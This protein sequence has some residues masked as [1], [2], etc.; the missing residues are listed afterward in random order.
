M[1]VKWFAVDEALS[2]RALA[3][4][5]LHLDKTIRIE[6]PALLVYE[7]GNATLSVGGPEL[8]AAA[9]EALDGFDLSV[10]PPSPDVDLD[11][12]RLAGLH[13]LTYYDASY[14]ASA[15]A[16]SAPLVTG[17]MALLEA[18][19]AAGMGIALEDVPLS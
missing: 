5:D 9:L 13:G 19:R 11:A 4:L 16:R 12:A 1:A 6:V 7:V 14:L 2:D 18:A 17:D 8:A 15:L 3:V 10:P